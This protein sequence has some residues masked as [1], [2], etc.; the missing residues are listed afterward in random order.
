M[1]RY[2]PLKTFHLRSALNLVLKFFANEVSPEDDPRIWIP[3]SLDSK[4]IVE[5]Y[6]ETGCSYIQYWVALSSN[7]DVVGIIG[8]YTE[9]FDEDE[10][11]WITWFC[12]DEKYQRQGIG[13]SLLSFCFDYSRA[14]QKKYLRVYTDPENPIEKNAQMLY[15]KFGLRLVTSEKYDNVVRDDVVVR[16]VYLG[17]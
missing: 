16:E 9:A 4:S 5:K 6:D 11:F 14:L 10:A 13:S 2:E 1:I 15:E 17:D 12:V 3:A 7:D 8:L